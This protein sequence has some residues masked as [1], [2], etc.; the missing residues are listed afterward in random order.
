MNKV[1]SFIPCGRTVQAKELCSSHYWQQW[2]GRPLTALRKDSPPRAR[3]VRT[4]KP[5]PTRAEL[6]WSKVDKTD[7]C[8]L[9]TAGR[10]GRERQYGKFGVGYPETTLA[11]R[12]AYEDANGPIPDG[13]QVDHVCRVTLCVNPAHLRIVTNK[14]NHENIVAQ[15]DSKTGVR[16]VYYDHRGYYYVQVT[17]NGKRHCGR[18][19]SSLDEAELAA[20]ALRNSL[21][22]HNNTDRR[23]S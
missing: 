15:R 7:T 11:H 10:C 2:S 19:Y 1:C 20:I 14:Q 4:P 5:K 21:Y 6:F 8:W 9:W 23:A 22:T 12:W 3:A 13:M 16:G 18:T 17:H